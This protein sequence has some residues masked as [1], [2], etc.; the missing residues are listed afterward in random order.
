MQALLFRF[1]SRDERADA[2]SR[3][4]VELTGRRFDMVEWSETDV[5]AAPVLDG[6]GEEVSPGVYGA[7]IHLMELAIHDHDPA[8]LWPSGWQVDSLSKTSFAVA[9][10]HGNGG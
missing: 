5:I 4:R 8:P 3:V 6:D 10:A 2:L 9:Q 7:T 1:S